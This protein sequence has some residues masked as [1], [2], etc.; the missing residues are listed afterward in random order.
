MIDCKGFREWIKKNTDYSD[1]V[2]SDI[3]SRARRAD[4]L[5]EWTNNEIYLFELERNEAY[6]H[7][8]ASVRSQMKKAVKL[9]F[10]YAG[11]EDC[12]EKEH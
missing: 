4:R 2:V 8:S 1:K 6:R 10:L 7:L 3:V 5:Q 12:K 9:Y 11:S